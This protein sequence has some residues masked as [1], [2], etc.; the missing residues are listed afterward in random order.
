LTVGNPFDPDVM[1]TLVP[2]VSQ[3]V[4]VVCGSQPMINAAYQCLRE[5]GIEPE[6]IHFERIWW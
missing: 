4:A 5:C 3:R 1:R 6:D 2:D